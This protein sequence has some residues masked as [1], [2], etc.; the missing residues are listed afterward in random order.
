MVF[1]ISQQVC[2]LTVSPLYM[3]M[4]F[5]ES[6]PEIGQCKKTNISLLL[7]F[8]CNSLTAWN[9]ERSLQKLWVGD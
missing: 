6:T 8:A 9:Q 3:E 7:L 4:L 1:R 2:L 5:C